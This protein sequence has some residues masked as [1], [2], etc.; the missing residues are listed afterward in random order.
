MAVQQGGVAMKNIKDALSIALGLIIIKLVFRLIPPWEGFTMLFED[1]IWM[2]IG[3][4]LTSY[5][6][7]FLIVYIII[8]IRRRK[9]ADGN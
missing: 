9:K 7:L 1:G 3:I 2:G 5:I 8:S 6:V 4:I